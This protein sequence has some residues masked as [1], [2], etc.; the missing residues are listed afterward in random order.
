[1]FDSPKIRML[2]EPPSGSYKRFGTNWQIKQKCKQ[3]KHN[4]NA[5]EGDTKKTIPMRYQLQEQSTGK[6][7]KVEV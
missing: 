3:L 5:R 1:M 4:G 2:Q 7:N 6:G